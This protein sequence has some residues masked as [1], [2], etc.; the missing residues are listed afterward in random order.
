MSIEPFHNCAHGTGHHMSTTVKIGVCNKDLKK[1]T[2][3]R[4]RFRRADCSTGGVLQ[5]KKQGHRKVI[6]NMKFQHIPA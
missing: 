6:W 3:V 2:E 4:P 5:Q 1:L